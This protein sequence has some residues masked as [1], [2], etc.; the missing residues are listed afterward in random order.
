MRW[1]LD[2][3]RSSAAAAVSPPGAVQE[4][5]EFS[6]L[7]VLYLHGNNITKLHEV[8]KL[9]KLGLRTLTERIVSFA[10]RGHTVSIQIKSPT[11][12]MTLCSTT[13]SVG[14]AVQCSSGQ[15]S[16]S[17]IGRALIGTAEFERR[18]EHCCRAL[19][20]HG[21]PIENVPNYRLCDS[22][23]SLFVFHRR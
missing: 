19:P 12:P 18:S 16:A 4:L 23:H 8:E 10:R 21:N 11:L 17:A 1:A 7:K 13:V 2:A 6:E 5:C 15:C 22:R 9:S 3:V 20:L 14:A